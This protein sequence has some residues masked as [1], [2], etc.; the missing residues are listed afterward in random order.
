MPVLSHRLAE[1][2]PVCLSV[3]TL[4]KSICPLWNC[5]QR[6][7]EASRWAGSGETAAN[8]TRTHGEAETMSTLQ[9][10]KY[11]PQSESSTSLDP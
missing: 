5:G 3:L 1:S 10:D 4:S 2:V 11:T 6:E 8:T 9:Y 7:G